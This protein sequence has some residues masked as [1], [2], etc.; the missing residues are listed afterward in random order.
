MK[1]LYLKFDEIPQIGFAHHFLMN[2]YVQNYGIRYDGIEIVYI[3]TGEITAQ[4]YGKKYDIEPGSILVFHRNMP[5]TLI[6]PKGSCQTHCSVHIKIKGD[7]LPIESEECF[8]KSGSGGVLIPFITPPCQENEEIKKELY[9]IVSTVGNMG[10]AG[11][12]SASLCAMGIL[13]KLDGMYRQK[14]YAKNSGASILEYKVKHFI[15]ENI[16]KDL[17]LSKIA[18]AMGKTP[19][20]LNSVFKNATG[21]G[22]RQYINKERARTICELMQIQGASFK[23]ACESVSILDVSYGYRLFKKQTGVTPAAFLAGKHLEK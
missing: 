4:L 23:M 21:M 1:G 10:E 11:R 7:I 8:L 14:L 5:L 20:Y 22:I 12:F 2:N 6:S 16:N 3:K 19:N 18:E 9:S 13:S 15:A 17:S